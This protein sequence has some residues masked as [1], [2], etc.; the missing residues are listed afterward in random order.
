MESLKD[1]YIEIVEGYD[2]LME[3][4]NDNLTVPIPILEYHTNCIYRNHLN[5]LHMSKKILNNDK[6]MILY[7]LESMLESILSNIEEN[8]YKY[9]VVDDQYKNGVY[10]FKELRL[11]FMSHILDMKKKDR[12]KSL[13]ES[14]YEG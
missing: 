3:V 6:Y 10:K 2:E 8:V 4:Y 14:I 7:K 9:T 11:M 1:I 12:K 13:K 5:I